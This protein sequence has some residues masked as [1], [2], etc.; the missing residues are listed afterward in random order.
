MLKNLSDSEFRSFWLNLI[1]Y[2]GKFRISREDAEEIANDAIL[3]AMDF[4]DENRGSFESLCKVILKNKL[5][6][7]KRDKAELYLMIYIDEFENN[8]SADDYISEL[9]T[10]QKNIPALMF[11]AN[12]R[13]KLKPDEVI[14]F[15]E[16]YKLCKET[17]KLNISEASKNLG[18]LPEKGW[19]VFRKIQ[20]KA[21]NLSEQR[22]II[23]KNIDHRADNLSEQINIMAENFESHKMIDY[24]KSKSTDDFLKYF[25]LPGED[26]FTLFIKSLNSDVIK[27][28]YK[29]YPQ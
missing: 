15:D 20:R 10:E 26:S 29:L 4:Y 21:N 12:L 1:A 14:F 6:N 28:L 7:F 25:Q 16:L 19:D 27:K 13:N 3:K 5:I 2:S 8:F 18:L 11:I 24:S 9:E 23:D 17:C 22:N